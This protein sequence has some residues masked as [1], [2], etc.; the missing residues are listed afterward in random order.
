MAA[1]ST[2]TLE[3]FEDLLSRVERL[4]RLLRAQASY[5][6]ELVAFAP[7]T[8]I[9]P[10]DE[11]I[12]LTPAEAADYLGIGLSTLRS[13]RD[14]IGLEPAVVYRGN[15]PRYSKSDLDRVRGKL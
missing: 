6:A 1:A 13:R 4:E 14:E 5:H 12:L 10:G 8:A 15:R 9:R 11:E 3:D 2:P 7:T